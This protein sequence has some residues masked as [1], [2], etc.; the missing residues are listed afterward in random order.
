[1]FVMLRKHE[2]EALEPTAS[3][4]IDVRHFV[5][6][7]NIHPQWYDRP[8]YLGPDGD[9][10]SYFALAKALAKQG[11]EGI[12]HWTMRKKEYVGALRSEGGYLLLITLHQQGDILTAEELEPPA[13]RKLDPKERQLAE[14]LVRALEDDFDPEQYHDEYR[15]RVQALIQAKRKGEEYVVDEEIPE[16][17]RGSLRQMLAASLKHMKN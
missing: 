2:L 4:D 17:S 11:K 1:L 3:R 15:E 13:G 5:P 10:A 9:Q 16:P 7:E 14:Q 6:S 12:A 8:Y